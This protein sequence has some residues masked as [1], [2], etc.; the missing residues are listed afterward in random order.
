MTFSIVSYCSN[1]TYFSS[2]ES[3]ASISA[4][5]S[6][7]S[8]KTPTFLVVIFH[9][10]FFHSYS[11][12]YLFSSQIKHF[13]HVFLRCSTISLWLC[14][15]SLSFFSISL[16]YFSLLYTCLY[17]SSTSNLSFLFC[18]RRDETYESFCSDILINATL[19]FFSRLISDFRPSFAS[20][21]HQA[22]NCVFIILGISMYLF[23][24]IPEESR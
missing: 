14:S 17:A 7:S 1:L 4:R 23:E 6:E 18:S 2:S 11:S 3:I 20:F 24:R 19:Y 9:M 15:W 13:F 8:L 12:W 16:M 22:E 10:S 21:Y 5:I